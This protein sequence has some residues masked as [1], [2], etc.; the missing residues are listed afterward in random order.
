MHFVDD[1]KWPSKD[2]KCTSKSFIILSLPYRTLYLNIQYK[3][4]PWYFRD[5]IGMSFPSLFLTNLSH[6]LMAK[7]DN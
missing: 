7:I 1:G 5:H 2:N 3:L 6:I 4:P